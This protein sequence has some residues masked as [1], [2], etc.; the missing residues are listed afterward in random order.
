MLL[1]AAPPR[2]FW[3][4]G[5]GKQDAMQCNNRGLNMLATKITKLCCVRLLSACLSKCLLCSSDFWGPIYKISYD[6]LMIIL[7]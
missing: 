2:F 5:D 7:R 4:H 3:V 1:C 6:N